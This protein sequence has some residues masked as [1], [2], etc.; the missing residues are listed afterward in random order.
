MTIEQ[1]KEKKGK[2]ESLLRNLS[3]LGQVKPQ[4]VC[5]LTIK[6][7]TKNRIITYFENEVAPEYSH[8]MFKK[9]AL[10]EFHKR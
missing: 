7:H 10:P 2:K 1:K 5:F 3:K 9:H 8:P 4:V 6:E